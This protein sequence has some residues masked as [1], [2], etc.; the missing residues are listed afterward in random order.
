MVD[1]NDKK[2]NLES[3]S[4]FRADMTQVIQNISDFAVLNK[5]L[6]KNEPVP[7]DVVKRVIDLTLESKLCPSWVNYS[8]VKYTLNNSLVTIN[9]ISSVPF[10]MVNK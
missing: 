1:S 3:D 8:T 2:V 5:H 4:T 10:V 6:K 7:P 9:S